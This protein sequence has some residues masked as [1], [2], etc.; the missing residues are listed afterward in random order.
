MQ[1]VV[2][3]AGR[4]K[5]D[6]AW[7][8]ADAE[9]NTLDR[10]FRQ[11][12]TLD[13]NGLVLASTRPLLQPG[14]T[15]EF[16]PLFA[17]LATALLVILLLAC[18]N[19]GNLQLARTIARHR[20]IAVRL[21]LG[22]G[23]GRVVRQIM[24]EAVCLATVA[25]LVGFGLSWVLPRLLLHLA[26]EDDDGL[27]F[28]PDGTAFVLA[29][30]LAVTTALLFALAPALQISRPTQPLVVSVRSGMDRRGRR[31]RA[32]L[33]GSQI[34]LSLMLLSGAGL[35]TRGILHIQSADLGFDV[36]DTLVA[37]MGM[38]DTVPRGERAAL[39][40]RVDAALRTSPLWPVGW[41]HQEP[42]STLRFVAEVRRSDQDASWNQDAYE[43][44]L[45]PDS[46]RVLGLEFVAGGPYD[47]R[48]EIRQAVINETLARMLF[49]SEPAVGRT[50]LAELAVAGA[51]FEA[52]TITGVVRDSFYTTPTDIVPLF[53]VAPSVRAQSFLLFRRDHPDAA[54]QMRTLLQSVDSRLQVSIVPAAANIA[55]A[56]DQRRFGA[57]LAWVLGAVGLTLATIGV[58][59]VFAHAVEE[60]RQELAVRVALGARARDVVRAIVA[61]HR[62][63]VG[64]GVVFGLV[65]SVAGGFVLRS[66]LFGLSPLDPVAYL[67]VTLLLVLAATLAT[68][69]PSRRAIRVDP[70]AT[71]KSE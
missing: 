15:D 51:T 36:H 13:G 71:L 66:Y 27:A 34:A 53:H 31:L 4:L 21:A 38:P 57:T 32:V 35:L 10:Q 9:L 58:F 23:R 48:P 3:M 12:A 55:R 47:P 24:T 49:R 7:S 68:V 70:A 61:V 39:T 50:V 2:S 60:R 67:G 54:S 28:V 56:L 8:Q 14:Q 18:A 59:G 5:P 46:F 1:Q 6:A 19:V 29:L 43:R 30:G 63:S 40:A 25:A 64:G 26:G 22:A 33:L 37:R 16:M 11:T 20:E 45:S 17:T 69:V 44:P 42:L 41:A 62:W 52:F 65:L